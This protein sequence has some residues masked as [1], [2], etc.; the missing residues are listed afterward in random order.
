MII[1]GSNENVKLSRIK[2]GGT[3]HIEDNK[4]LTAYDL[5]AGTDIRIVDSEDSAISGIE[6]VVG[7]IT[8]NMVTGSDLAGIVSTAGD[9][10]IEEVSSSTV[11]NI[12][13]AEGVQPEKYHGPRLRI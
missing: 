7:S 12:K 3:L 4:D 6:A 9:V 8:I 2:A 5:A 11:N 13:A 1:A 10:N